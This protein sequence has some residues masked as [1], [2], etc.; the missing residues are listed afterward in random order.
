M[1]GYI[2][3]TSRPYVRTGKR[4]GKMHCPACQRIRAH[5]RK[6]TGRKEIYKCTYCNRVQVFDLPEGVLS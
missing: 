1:A 4:N 2:R 5:S 6:V 3:K